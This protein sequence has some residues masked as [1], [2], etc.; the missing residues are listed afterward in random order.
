MRIRILW[1]AGQTTAT[2]RATP[3]AEQLWSALPIRSSANT[4]GDEVYFDTLLAVDREED[5]QQVVAPGTVAF[6]TEGDSLALPFGPTPISRGSEC[7]L[8]SPCNILGTLDGDPQVLRTVRGGDPIS[9]ER[10]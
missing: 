7:R 4:W 2:L 1:P 3:T 5:A 8:A 6:W 10:A 9:V